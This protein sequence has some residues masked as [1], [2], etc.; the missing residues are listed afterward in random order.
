MNPDIP[1][2]FTVDHKYKSLKPGDFWYRKRKGRSNTLV[3]AFPPRPGLTAG[4][5]LHWV[6]IRDVGHE[7]DVKSSKTI[8]DWDGNV[9][10]PTVAGS[11][12]GMPH[13]HYWVINGVLR[14]KKKSE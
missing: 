9:E 3:V 8:R 13:C 14:E 10:H 2:T 12:G 7:I 5:E 4:Y 6:P 1:M 11:W